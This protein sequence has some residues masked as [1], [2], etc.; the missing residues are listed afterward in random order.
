M[1][2]SN[3]VRATILINGQRMR[4]CRP[5]AKHAVIFSLLLIVPTVIVGQA[6]PAWLRSWNEAVASRPATLKAVGRIASKTEPGTPLIIRGQVVAPDGDPVGNVIV[7]GYHRD[8]EGL[9]FGSGDSTTTTWRLQGWTRTDPEGRFMFRTIRPAPDHMGREGAHIH[10]TLESEQYGR[11][12]APTVFFADDPAVKADQRRQSE[13]AGEFAWVLDTRSI[14]GIE[15]LEV[16]IK[17][18]EDPDF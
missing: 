5:T 18:D 4:H 6:D 7:H 1:I 14:D 13:Q 8:Q 11:Q 9:D 3:R 12:W 17:L 2:L 15:H 16:K 10:F